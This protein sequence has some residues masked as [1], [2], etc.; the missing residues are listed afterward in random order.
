MRRCRA[1]LP[2]LLFSVT[3]SK[4]APRVAAWLVVLLFAATSFVARADDELP[5]RVGR[6]AGFAGQLYLSP[7]ERP[8]EWEAIGINYPVTSGDN[9]WVSGDGRAEVDYGGGQ[10]RLAGDT[11]AH[12][13]RLDDRQLALFIAHGRLIVRVRVQDP[14]DATRVDTPNTQVT[15]TRPGLY[16]IEVE[17]DRQATTV[18]V[19]EGEALVGLAY[20]AQQA[21][22]GQTVSAIGAAPANADIRNSAGMDGFDTWSANRDRRYERGRSTTYVSRQMVG[23]AEL[24]EHGAWQTYPEYGAVWFPASVAPGW[25][26][27]RDGYWTNVGAWGPTWVDSAPWGYAPFH[28]GRWA[29]IGGRW[30]WCPGGYVARPVW[31]PAL[32]A[33]F[34]GPGWGL[35]GRGGAPVYGWV[36]LGWREPYFPSWRGCSVDCWSHHNRPHGVNLA[37]RPNAPPMRYAN[38]AVPGAM[39]AVTGSTFVGRKPVA[40][41]AVELPASLATVAP[42]L[43]GAPELKPGAIPVPIVRPGLSGVP[44]PASSLYPVARSPRA[45]EG[46]TPNPNVSPGATFG[47]VQASG[48]GLGSVPAA[49]ARPPRADVK[50]PQPERPPLLRPVPNPAGLDAKLP[51]PERP[52]PSRPTPISPA[53]TASP[54]GYG[55]LSAVP[56]P[57][58]L[59]PYG[60]RDAV[61]PVPSG[62]TPASAAPG[63]APNPVQSHGEVHVNPTPAGLSGVRPAGN[64]QSNA[65]APLGVPPAQ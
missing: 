14:G 17:P 51:L 29:W 57:A 61:L 49:A 47:G 12:V 46:F 26:P 5:G 10:F 1:R 27:Y 65:G 44:A 43:R 3:V 53:P 33:W 32:V 22:P 56:R 54:Q 11:S 16:R 42:V 21:L 34:G 36:P 6:I 20:G 7:P 48:G 59:P 41:N 18:I 28:Y 8:T 60:N 37:E 2:R 45:G 9:L 62:G 4:I 50:L 63:A 19:R 39:T 24:D 23:Y 40:A 13:S 35:S 15:L 25:A 58:P 31:A 55:G 64:A 52:P 38:G 30:G